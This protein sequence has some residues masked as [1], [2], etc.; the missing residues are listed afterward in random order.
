[1]IKKFLRAVVPAK[2]R[3]LVQHFR[4]QGRNFKSLSHTYGQ[5]QT[6]RDWASIDGSRQPIPWYTYPA[7]EFLS[8]LDFAGLKVFE[9]GSGNS[10]VWWSTRASHITSV[11]D[12]EVWYEKVKRA[13]SSG[14]VEYCLEKNPEKYFSMADDTFDIFIVD[15]KHRREC[16]EHVVGLGGG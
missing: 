12:D 9:Y 7:T 3:E 14:N 11:E 1:M 8:H 15:G 5:W 4:K 13:L 16:L 6:I 2:V 10:T